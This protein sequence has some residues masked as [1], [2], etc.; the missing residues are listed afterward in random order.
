MQLVLDEVTEGRRRRRTAIASPQELEFKALACQ[1]VHTDI[2]AIHRQ[3]GANLAINH[4]RLACF[5]TISPY[6]LPRLFRRLK[7]E[8]PE[9][10]VSLIEGDQSRIHAA[11]ASGEVELAMMFDENLADGLQ[12]ESMAEHTPYV[13][14]VGQSRIAAQDLD[15]QPMVLL[16]TP[17]SPEYFLGLLRDQGVEPSV[18]WQSSVVE[19]VRGMVANGLGYALLAS[20]PASDLCY[21][22]AALIARPL[23]WTAKTSRVMLVRR[24]GVPLSPMAER[25]AW[26]CREDFGVGLQ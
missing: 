17:P 7:T 4:L 19:T 14:M 22:G 3:G 13:R 9:A 21:D 1:R 25:F 8:T 23:A 15:G 5:Y 24:A 12:A 18:V 10:A 6:V 11:L 2:A 16:N 20:R 26:L